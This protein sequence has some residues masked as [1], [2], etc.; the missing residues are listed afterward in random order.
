MGILWSSKG[1]LGTPLGLVQ[2]RRASSRVEAGTS[3]FLCIYDFDCSISAALE[4][5]SQDS[6]CIE[7]WNSACLSSC[8][9]GDRPFVKLYLEPAGFSGRCTGLSLALRVLTSCTGLHS[10]RCLVIGFL[11]RRDREI[12]V[13]Q[14][15]SPPTRL[16]LEFLREASLILRCDEKVSIPFQTKQGIRPSCRDQEGRRGSEEVVPGTS[17][18]LWSETGMW[19]NF[20]CCINIIKY[21]FEFQDED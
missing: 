2:W 16:C 11:S 1:P 19:G 8:S 6:S 15:V 10:K 14:N 21:L 9:R 18:F 5:Q 7:E 12:G 20:L 13:F 3:E 17:V 4:L